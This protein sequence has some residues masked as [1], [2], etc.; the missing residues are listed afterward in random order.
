MAITAK[1]Y[2]SASAKMFNGD[3]NATDT[4]KVALLTG[5]GSF[6]ATHT[7]WSDVSA[8]E[9]TGTTGYTAGGNP[10]ALTSAT[11]DAT[12]A[13]YALGAV[14]WESATMTFS[15]AVIYSSDSGALM[16]HLAYSP[17]QVVS[18]QTYTLNAPSPAPSVTPT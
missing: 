16:M 6:N 12:K 2:P 1:W 5:A 17:Q 8:Y 3:L 4:L 14:S 7:A 13:V 18:N 9:I 10:V 11:S 15:N